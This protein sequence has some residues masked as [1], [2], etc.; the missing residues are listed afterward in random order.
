MEMGH[1]PTC[2]MNDEDSCNEIWH[3]AYFGAVQ[4]AT[5]LKRQFGL[6]PALKKIRKQRAEARKHQTDQIDRM[7]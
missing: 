5:F 3:H 1:S 2:I 7:F 4:L 6:K